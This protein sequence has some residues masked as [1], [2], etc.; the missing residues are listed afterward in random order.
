MAS[1]GSV[2]FPSGLSSA[3][4]VSIAV[5]PAATAAAW[6]YLFTFEVREADLFLVFA[7]LLDFV[8]A[9]LAV[10]P[11]ARFA[12]DLAALLLDAVFLDALHVSSSCRLCG[13]V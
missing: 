10:F 1:P 11:A 6:P 7:G 13:F 8:L 4:T 12:E 3:R 9:R 5:T 2:F